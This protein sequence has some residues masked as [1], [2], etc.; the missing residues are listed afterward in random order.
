[1]IV[2]HKPPMKSVQYMKNL[3]RDKNSFQKIGQSAKKVIK[4]ACNNAPYNNYQKKNSIGLYPIKAP[5]NDQYVYGSFENQISGISDQPTATSFA[6]STTP[7]TPN[8]NN[9]NKLQKR[10]VKCGKYESLLDFVENREREI[11]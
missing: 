10:K 9:Q 3:T 4:V 1:M 7:V 6:T 11:I 2:Y 8:R 5:Q